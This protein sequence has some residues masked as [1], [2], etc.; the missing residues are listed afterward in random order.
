MTC[1]LCDFRRQN[2]LDPEK[3]SIIDV[4][5]NVEEGSMI[6]ICKECLD[7]IKRI[8]GEPAQRYIV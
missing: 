5:E 1:P 3:L 4:L 6:E 7:E 8:L 2:K